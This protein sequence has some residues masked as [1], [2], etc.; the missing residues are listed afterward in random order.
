M[1]RELKGEPG[2]WWLSLLYVAS[3]LTAS[4][5]VILLHP[6]VDIVSFVVTSPVEAVPG[7]I[8]TVAIASGMTAVVWSCLRVPSVRHRLRP[9]AASI[10]ASAA[11][12]VAVS[13]TW[14]V[15]VGQDDGDGGLWA[16]AP[17]TLAM[18][19]PSAVVA[20]CALVVSRAIQRDDA[21]RAAVAVDGHGAPLSP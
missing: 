10:T 13:W 8:T 17:L 15:F 7:I 19:A 4:V 18:C 5:A 16:R 9:G 20:I 21:R 6:I 11:T 12:F 14:F 1:R 2:R 3:V